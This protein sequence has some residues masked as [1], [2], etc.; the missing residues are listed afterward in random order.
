M[1]VFMSE[2]KRNSPDVA[3]F[4]PLTLDSNLRA[5]LA[6][7]LKAYDYS[8][9]AKTDVWDFALEIDAL[10]AQ[11]LM[12]S[13]LRWLVVKGLVMH[14]WEMSDLNDRH[15]SFRPSDGLK[16]VAETCMVL[17]PKGAAFAREFLR[18]YAGAGQANSALDASAA[19][20]R[21]IAPAPQDLL[22]VRETGVPAPE[23][24]RW[25][26]ARRK[27]C[28]AE[29][30]VKRFRVPAPNQEAILDAFEEEGWPAQIDDPL[31]FREDIDPR[32]RLHDAINRLN[33][34]QE[35]PLLHFHGNGSGTG[36]SWE[37]RRNGHHLPELTQQ[38][39]AKLR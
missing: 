14:G 6:R 32:T 24:P 29:S 19:S 21:E 38:P 8:L 3:Q 35:Q 30:I 22:V 27:L 15:R 10:Y 23:K 12:I 17:T 5:G 26:A 33:G 4:T 31:P 39:V 11:G 9:D 28:V 2:H 37:F 16:F 13:D 7:L 36:I 20:H 34:C 18:E 1:E 25:D